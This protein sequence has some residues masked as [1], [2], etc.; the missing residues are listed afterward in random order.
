MFDL[1]API[2]PG[3][4]AA[5]VAMGVSA[6]PYIGGATKP[7]TTTLLSPG[8]VR[9]GFGSVALWVR[10]GRVAQI[11]VSQGYSGLLQGGI[12]IGSMIA[13]IHALLGSVGEDDDDNLVVVG[14][15]GWCF[16]TEEWLSGRRPKENPSVRVTE[17]YVFPVA[18]HTEEDRGLT[19]G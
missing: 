8:H 11:G 4:S 13:D 16:E 7:T 2:I 10:D 1:S 5:G 15:V 18:A 12:G 6:A 9:Y 14:I 17:I 3:H 19:P